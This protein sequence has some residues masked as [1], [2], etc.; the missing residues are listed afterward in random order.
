[1]SPTFDSTHI[2][3]ANLLQAVIHTLIRRTLI[4]C[5]ACCIYILVET[6]SPELCKSIDRL[7]SGKIML[8]LFI[9]QD[10]ENEGRIDPNVCLGARGTTLRT[11]MMSENSTHSCAN[12]SAVTTDFNKY[13]TMLQEQ[14]VHI[15]SILNH[16]VR[17]TY[18]L[19]AYVCH[20]TE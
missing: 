2:V 13:F 15:P 18:F 9:L 7:F 11:G 6:R 12:S 1:M 16:K 5:T 8:V 3:V 17:G 14:F 19:R 20:A 10:D 4:H